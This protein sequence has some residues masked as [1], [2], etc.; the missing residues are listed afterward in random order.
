MI[1]GHGDDAYLYQRPVVSD[2]SSNI[3]PPPAGH[4]ALMAHLAARPELLSHYPEPE[5][6]SLEQMIAERLKISPTCVIVTSGATDAI[7]LVAQT[8][9]LHPVIPQPTFSEYEDACAS[10]GQFPP[11]PPFPSTKRSICWLCNPNN[12]TGYVYANHEVEMLTV[13]HDLVVVDQSYEWYTEQF[14]IYPRWACRLPN[15]LLIHSMTKTY[16][17]PGLRLGYITAPPQLAELLRRQLRPWAVSALAVEAGKYLVEHSEELRCRPD[18]EEARRLRL[19]L[20][21]IDGISVRP[22]MTNF[23][24]CQLED[25]RLTAAQLKDYLVCE[26]GILIRD[27][28]NFRKLSPQH[29][30]VAAQTPQENDA[31]VAA[32]SQFLNHHRP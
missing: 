32:V 3:C 10:F 11:S 4:H 16:G 30:R 29:F 21:R 26:H 17:V 6:W 7:Y 23:M 22:T 9:R 31:L 13:K 5:P 15:L 27:A 19:Q 12:P 1:K 8:F 28:S 2:F 25:D 20:N 18:F 14:V 24:L